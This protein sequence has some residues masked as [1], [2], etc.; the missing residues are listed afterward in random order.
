[1]QEKAY[2]RD[3]HDDDFNVFKDV[4]GSVKGDLLQSLIALKLFH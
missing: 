4:A 1:M 3:E 2:Y